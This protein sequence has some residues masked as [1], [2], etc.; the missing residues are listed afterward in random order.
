MEA[1]TKGRQNNPLTR[2]KT[3]YQNTLP[4][5]KYI[6]VYSQ[7]QVMEDRVWSRTSLIDAV[8]SGFFEDGTIFMHVDTGRCV[9]AEGKMGFTQNLIFIDS[10]ELQGRA[11]AKHKRYL[12]DGV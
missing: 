3:F 7:E 1:M 12:E 6:I 11:R 2:Y 4:T 8:R 5:G 9:K 10:L